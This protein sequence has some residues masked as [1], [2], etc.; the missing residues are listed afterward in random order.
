MLGAGERQRAMSGG[1][2]DR[3]VAET[4]LRKSPEVSDYFEIDPGPNS[5]PVSV[6]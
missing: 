1:V 5:R 4:N 6:S 2:A 3:E